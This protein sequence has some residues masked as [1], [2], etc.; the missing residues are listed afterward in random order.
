MSPIPVCIGD[1]FVALVCADGAQFSRSV[2]ALPDEHP[3]VRF[4]A[5][6]AVFAGEVLAGRRPGP[7]TDA[8]AAAWARR[9]ALP[10]DVYREAIAAGASVEAIAEH[11]CLP[12]EQ[13]QAR[14]SDRERRAPPTRVALHAPRRPDAAARQRP[15]RPRAD[16]ADAAAVV[17]AQAGPLAD[18]RTLR[19]RWARGTDPAAGGVDDPFKGGPDGRPRVRAAA[20][21]GARP[22]RPA[23]A[24][25]A[26]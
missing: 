23:A 11:I 19:V 21:R 8:A 20:R 13:V 3:T 7:Y 15:R 25:G 24:D 5:L 14:A 17:S 22:L 4:V 6:M 2:E 12:A 1:E 10:L 16:H 9:E 18:G 26:A